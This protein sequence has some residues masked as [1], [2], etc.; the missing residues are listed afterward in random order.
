MDN[1]LSLEDGDSAVIIREEIRQQLDAVQKN[2]LVNRT[3]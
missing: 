1:N 3:A 2:S